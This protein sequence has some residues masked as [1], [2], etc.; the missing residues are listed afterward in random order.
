M[1]RTLCFL[2][3]L[4]LLSL[5]SL[6]V[7]L[8]HNFRV[9]LSDESQAVL[10]VEDGEEAVDAIYKFQ[11]NHGLTSSERSVLQ[12]KVCTRV[13][14]ARSK[15]IIWRTNVDIDGKRIGD[16]VLFEGDE[17]IDLAHNFVKEHNQSIALRASLLN[18]ACESVKCSREKPGKITISELNREEIMSLHCL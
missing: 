11:N 14:C 17:P 12:S 18:E 15:A 7:A 2:L 8:R 1:K 13:D 6:V 16:L 9:Q 5:R 3:I 10:T 4:C